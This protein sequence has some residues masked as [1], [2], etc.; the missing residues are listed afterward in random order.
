MTAFHAPPR[1]S[2][3][4]PADPAKLLLV[5]PDTRPP[6]Y[7]FPLTLARAAGREPL[8]PPAEALPEGNRPGKFEVL[9]AWLK[10]FA[11]FAQTL[12]VSLETLCLGGMI[13]ARR[14]SDP[15]PEALQKLELLT[16]LK[17]QNPGLRLYACG[18][19]VRVAHDDDPMEEKPYYGSHGGA[20]R[21]FSEAFDRHARHGGAEREEILRHAEAGLPPEI[22]A[23]WLGTRARNHQLHQ[24]ALDLTQD[25]II[26]HLCLTLDDTSEYGLAAHDRRALEARTDEL[27]LWSKVDI[28][29]GADEVPAVL[30]AR[31]LQEQPTRVYV[32][33]SGTLGE[34][35]RLRYEDRSAGE[36]VKAQ[37]RAANCIRVDTLHEADL[38]LALNTPG[39]AQARTQPD[40]ATVDTPARHL[41][42]FV[43]FVA[44]C[45]AEGRPVSLA[46]IAY[47][48]GA[49]KRLMT[50]LRQRV[51]LAELA[52]FSAWNTAGNTIGSAIAM[53]VVAG[54]LQEPAAWTEALFGRLVDDYLYQAEV[55]AEVRACLQNPSPYDLGPQRAMAERLIGELLTPRAEALWQEHF[56]GH[57][58]RLDWQAPG[59][60]WPRL[61]TGVFPFRVV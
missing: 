26:E 25:G 52:G 18:V 43:D 57:G 2:P 59:L 44:R 41:P 33:T 30:L 45:L 51:P 34:A 14:V 6:T 12:I 46:D 35:A 39:S 55:R 28:Y 10:S 53:G 42:E 17:R 11:P 31:A 29:P 56:A 16:L 37:L 21:A 49:E 38:V 15:L 20:L 40:Y 4:N 27:G 8:L 47:P 50:L 58:Y 61:F 54:C 3:M 36:L 32:R 5:P 19:V 1:T 23:D 22:L 9:E 60:A 13:P 24:R 48:N 7:D